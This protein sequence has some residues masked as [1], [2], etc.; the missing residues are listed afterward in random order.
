MN[1][2]VL[3][4]LHLLRVGEDGD[5]FARNIRS[6]AAADA[7]H[8][9]EFV[10]ENFDETRHRFLPI[11]EEPLGSRTPGQLEMAYDQS[12]HHLCVVRVKQRLQ[13]DG[14]E[15]AALLSEVSAFIENVS[16]TSAHPGREI[17]SARAEYQ[18][19]AIGHVLATVI[20]NPFHDSGRAGITNRKAL[21]SHAV[22]ES[23]TTG[24]AVKRYIADDDV[25]L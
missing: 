11:V 10:R 8:A 14:F 4:M 9:L 17:S 18:H 1:P 15:I 13:I 19:Q 21:A 20:A 2:V 16:D 3:P 24:G 5:R 6:I 22:K 7:Q 23:F 25:F 12:L